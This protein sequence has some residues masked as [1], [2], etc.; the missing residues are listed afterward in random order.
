M[1]GFR[2]TID[3][4]EE[5]SRGTELSV[6]ERVSAEMRNGLSCHQPWEGVLSV[7]ETVSLISLYKRSTVI[8]QLIH[9]LVRSFK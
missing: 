4:C 8:S 2:L 9:S 3:K 6:C 7:N 5:S 1:S